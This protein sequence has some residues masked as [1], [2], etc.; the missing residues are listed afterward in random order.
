MLVLVLVLVLVVALVLVLAQ[1][2]LQSATLFTQHIHPSTHRLLGPTL[3]RAQP[4]H[5]QAQAAGLTQHAI[6]RGRP[7]APMPLHAPDP[8]APAPSPHRGPQDA[9]AHQREAEAG[10]GAR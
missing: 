5:T 7:P 1:L 9:G 4:Q 3:I 6:A 2:S 8:S 10:R